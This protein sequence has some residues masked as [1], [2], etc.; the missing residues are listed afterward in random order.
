MVGVAAAAGLDGGPGVEG[1]QPVTGP[2]WLVAVKPLVQVEDDVRLGFEVR[3]AG[4]DPGPVLPGLDRVLGQDPQDGR[5]RDEAAGRQLGGQ[6]GAGPPGQRHPGGGGQLAGQCDHRGPLRR[7][8]PPRPPGSGQVIQPVQAPGG[9]PASPPSGSIDADS[10]LRGDAGVIPAAGGVQHDLRPQPVPPGGLGPADAHLQVLRSAAVNVTGT[11]A[12]SGIRRLPGR[13][14]RRDSRPGH[15]MIT[16]ADARAAQWP[17]ARSDAGRIANR[18]GGSRSTAS[19]STPASGR[20]AHERNPVRSRNCGH[21]RQRP[22]ASGHPERVGAGRHGFTGQR[23]QVLTR[24]EDDGFDPLARARSATPARA[25][26]PSPDLGLTN[27]TGRPADQRAAS[28][29]VTAVSWPGSSRVREYG[30][31]A[32]RL[33]AAVTRYQCG[34]AGGRRGGRL[35]GRGRRAA[36]G[37][38]RRAGRRWSP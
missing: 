33:L 30:R 16:S 29:N 20:D 1:Q 15:A 3:S 2:Q 26:L 34:G 9:K 4:A 21:D 36:A 28:H 19:P 5:R 17:H 37:R 6:F 38:P 25:A 27:S 31:A 12:G 35:R 8:D 23:G 32:G 24:G 22:V 10:H 7:A 11:A 13:S 14:R 18:S